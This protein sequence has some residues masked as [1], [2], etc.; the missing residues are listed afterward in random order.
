MVKNPSN[1]NNS[2]V[3]Y[4]P[5]G[6]AH[7]T[8]D[9]S[10][11]ISSRFGKSTKINIHSSAQPNS[12][13]HLGTTATLMSAFA[14][15]K[16]LKDKFKVPV[17]LKFEYD[18]NSPAEK[19][20][21][22]DVIYSKMQTQQE[23]DGV[24]RDK[25]FIKEFEYLFSY[26]EKKSGVNKTDR[27]FEEFQRIPFVRE[28][29]IQIIK[30]DE[31]KAVVSPSERKLHIRFPC[32]HCGYSDK[33]GVY[34]Q[35]VDRSDGLHLKSK[36]FQHGET[37]LL[38]TLANEKFVDFN[39]PIMDIIQGALFIEEDLLESALCIMY[40][41]GDWSGVWASDVLE[42]GLSLLGYKYEQFPLHFYAPIIED[43]S[44]AKFSKS[45]YIKGDTYNQIPEQLLN[46]RKFRETFG[47]RGLDLIWEEVNDWVS[48]PKKFFRNYSL[49]Y[50][51]SIFSKKILI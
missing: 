23:V 46:L 16:H 13:P 2:K 32:P 11:L 26:L 48:D 25:H 51:I 18:N 17:T 39:T 7:I 45:L 42:Q 27:T 40:D 34:F 19:V 1:I 14:L 41:G 38:L 35:C 6:I 31:F 29:L 24:R 49:D 9:L 33:S 21:V 50:F 10:D 36:C 44:G 20:K 5:V 43:W 12:Y 8:K 30:S 4:P 28:K 3:V 22:D 37:D 47:D 15:G